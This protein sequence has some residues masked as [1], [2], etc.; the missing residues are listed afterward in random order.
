MLVVVHT[1]WTLENRWVFWVVG[2]CVEDF[3]ARQARTSGIMCWWV[4]EAAGLTGLVCREWC[5][6]VAEMA[7]ETFVY[8]HFCCA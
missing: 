2:V 3:E 5:Y 6:Y 8:L 1:V 4:S 7:G